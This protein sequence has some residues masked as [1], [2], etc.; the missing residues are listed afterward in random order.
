MK[1]GKCEV[2]QKVTTERIKNFIGHGVCLDFKP[3]GVWLCSPEC[4]SAYVKMIRDY[5]RELTDEKAK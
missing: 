1:S 3:P 4:K 5:L 2:C